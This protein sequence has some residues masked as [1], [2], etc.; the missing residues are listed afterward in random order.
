[1]RAA[2][3]AAPHDR[4]DVLMR[5]LVDYA[6]GP[7]TTRSPQ[8][9]S[10]TPSSRRSTPSPTGTVAS[11]GS[12]SA[13][14]STGI[15]AWRSHPPIS[16]AFPDVGGYLSGLTLSDH[17]PDEWVGWFARTLEHA[18]TSATTTLAAVADLVASWPG[19]WTASVRRRRAS[20]WSSR[21]PRIRR[22]SEDGRE[23][24]RRQPPTAR[25]A[26]RRSPSG[27]CCAGG[28]ARQ[29]RAGSPA[30]LVGRRRTPRSPHP[31]ND[32]AIAGDE[33]GTLADRRDEY[34]SPVLGFV[35]RRVRRRS[36]RPSV[37][38]R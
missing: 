2:H 17:G 9:R 27:E 26:S 38:R 7:G 5:D 36:L 37:S 13:G 31:V 1:M 33:F 30:P 34:R 24:A 28:R 35:N 15:S 25:T 32:R 19:R 11:D 3:V 23:P 14:C 18:A 29:P 6:N 12:S 21:S 20:H 8:R 16:V 10:C 22:S 4:I